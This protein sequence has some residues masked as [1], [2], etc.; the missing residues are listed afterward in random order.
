MRHVLA[1]LTV[2]T[3]GALTATA[4]DEKYASKEGKYTVQFPA[5]GKVK[6]ETKAA[7]TAKMEFAATE[8]NGKGFMVMYMEL[9]KGAQNLPAKTLLDAGETGGVDQSG[10]KL[11]S[12][13]DIEFGN[14]K[15]PGREFV[16]EKDGNQA[17]SRIVVTKSRLYV[18]TVAGPKDFA[19]SKEAVAFLDSFQLTK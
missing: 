10:G 17:N 19:T 14:D 9:P 6:N 3:L 1:A 7:G 15:L 2:V 4:A 11:V 18:V 16:V 5:G 13:K 12:K 8:V